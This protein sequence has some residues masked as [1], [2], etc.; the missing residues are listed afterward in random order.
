[1]ARAFRIRP[2]EIAKSLVAFPILNEM[3]SDAVATKIETFAPYQRFLC[4]SSNA[5]YCAALFADTNQK[6]FICSEQIYS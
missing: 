1:M 2:F 6:I 4:L 5:R 3:L